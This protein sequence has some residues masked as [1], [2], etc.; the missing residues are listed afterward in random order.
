METSGLTSVMHVNGNAFSVQ[1]ASFVDDVSMAV[2]SPASQLC[3]KISQ[4]TS[5]AYDTYISYGM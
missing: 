5:L 1:D 2:L 4:V 3:D